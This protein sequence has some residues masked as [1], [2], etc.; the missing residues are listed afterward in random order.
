MGTMASL[1][2]LKEEEE[3]ESNEE[4][5]IVIDW[6]L[7][8]HSLSQIVGEGILC[9]LVLSSNGTLLSSFGAKTKSVKRIIP[10]LVESIWRITSDVGKKFVDARGLE[11]MF[12]NCKMGRIA[13]SVIQSIDVDV[14]DVNEPYFVC[15]LARKKMDCGY[16]KVKIELITDQL[17]KILFDEKEEENSMDE[18]DEYTK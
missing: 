5:N 9:V 11:L 6:R 15:L 7:F 13:I 3:N 17:A 1:E 8:S 10:W 2:A 14:D 16:L 18:S 12:A 4:H